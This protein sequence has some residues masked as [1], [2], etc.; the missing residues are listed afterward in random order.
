MKGKERMRKVKM[1]FLASIVLLLGMSYT[2]ASPIMAQT[3]DKEITITGSVKLS[4]M[5]WNETMSFDIF[6]DDVSNVSTVTSKNKKFEF[7]VKVPNGTSK[8]IVIGQVMPVAEQQISGVVYDDIRFQLT[9]NVSNEGVTSTSVIATN[10][11]DNKTKEFSGDVIDL[12]K[13]DGINTSSFWNQYTSFGKYYF[14]TAT[15]MLGGTLPKG[16]YLSY[17][18]SER[19]DFTGTGGGGSVLIQ[20]EGLN[21]LDY[22]FGY[23][24]GMVA[25]ETQTTHLYFKK[26]DN[27]FKSTISDLNIYEIWIKM[28]DHGDGTSDTSYS[29]DGVNFIPGDTIPLAFEDV[30]FTR[31]IEIE[32]DGGDSGKAMFDLYE[33]TE[34]TASMSNTSK[35]L[36]DTFET[37]DGK[38]SFRAPEGMYFLIKKPMQRTSEEK[39]YSFE[40][41][42]ENYADKMVFKIDNEIVTPEVPEDPDTP[43]DEPVVPEVPED[44]DTSQDEPIIPEVPET[45]VIPEPPVTVPENQDNTNVIKQ[46]ELTVTDSTVEKEK[47]Q[48]GVNTSDDTNL[49]LCG[50]I[51]LSSFAGILYFG[52]K[53]LASK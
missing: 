39:L 26:V 52:K 27:N 22:T 45:P 10:G 28:E 5:K 4:H 20:R 7:K 32:L 31:P 21:K 3:K 40:V 35:T 18:Y 16:K 51:L 48:I 41:T 53:A 49:F 42:R 8:N 17:A 34:G 29:F 12:D 36:I 46:P 1:F 30:Y 24:A 6:M 15:T 2:T 47:A 9:V 11:K 25:N 13:M 19:M 33:Y 44:P 23:S 50:I 37:T 38:L 43:Q 14:Q